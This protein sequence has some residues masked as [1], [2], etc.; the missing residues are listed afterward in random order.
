MEPFGVTGRAAPVCIC[1]V[2]SAFRVPS[3]SVALRPSG[4]FRFDHSD[5]IRGPIDEPVDKLHEAVDV[6]ERYRQTD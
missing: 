6:I 2:I 5:L 4:D 3:S 1:L